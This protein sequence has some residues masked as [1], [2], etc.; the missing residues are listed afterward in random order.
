MGNI[1]ELGSSDVL[2]V[3]VWHTISKTVPHG[4]PEN[5]CLFFTVNKGITIREFIEQIN[6]HRRPEY[7]I[8]KLHTRNGG[9][10]NPSEV[11]YR[12]DLYI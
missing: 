6:K 2:K 4:W 7:H 8:K 5:G 10:Y 9:I 1:L 3:R 12:N 11:L